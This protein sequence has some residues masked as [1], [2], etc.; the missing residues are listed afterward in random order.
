MVKNYKIDEN[1]MEYRGTKSVLKNT[2]KAQRVDGS[3]LLQNNL[4]YTLMGFERS[5]PIK[6]PSKQLNKLFFS[7]LNKTQGLNPWFIIG[8]CDAE[9]CFSVSIIIDKRIKGRIGW[10]IMPSF[11]ISLQSKGINLL[12]QLQKFTSF[13]FGF[14]FLLPAAN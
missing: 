7:T 9:A 4:R 5:Y 2:V 12:L 11:Q 14:F 3:W 13:F 10:L 6:I 8:F 1:K